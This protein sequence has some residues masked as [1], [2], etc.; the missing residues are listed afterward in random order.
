M[1][2]STAHLN[3]NHSTHPT[4]ARMIF[5]SGVM[6]SVSVRRTGG[7]RSQLRGENR[8]PSSDSASETNTECQ[9]KFN[10][11]QIKRFKSAG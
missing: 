4:F 2:A 3:L 9:I 8:T 7:S 6:A 10:I 1:V 5:R 11:V